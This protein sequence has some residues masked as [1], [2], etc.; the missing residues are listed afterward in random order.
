MI[1]V[2]FALSS[3]ASNRASQDKS[4]PR[5]AIDEAIQVH[6]DEFRLCYEHSKMMTGKIV[7]QWI[8]DG[9][10][11]ASDTRVDPSKTTLADSGL[12][13]C[14]VQVLSRTQ[15]PKIDGRPVTITYPFEY[16]NLKP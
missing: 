3:C 15:F 12:Q 10:G 1:F 16:T 4:I 5:D 7:A 6:R 14:V 2:L 8:I 11:R 13:E 9:S